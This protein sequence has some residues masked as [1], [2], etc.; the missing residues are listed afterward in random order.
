MKLKQ[1][2]ISAVVVVFV[3]FLILVMRPVP[4]PAEE[5]CLTINGMVTFV[6]ESEGKDVRIKLKDVDQIFYINRGLEAG[7]S[8]IQLN[9]DILHR[10]ITIKYPRYWTPFDPT[11]SIKHISKIEMDGKTVYSELD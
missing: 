11:N 2:I 5:D 8:L 4:I 10:Y 6:Y 1:W 7:L 3:A 9:N